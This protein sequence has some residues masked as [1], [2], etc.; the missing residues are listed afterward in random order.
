MSSTLQTTWTGLE[1]ALRAFLE[2]HDAIPRDC[3][4][5]LSQTM[6]T[7]HHTL[8]DEYKMLCEVRR[9]ANRLWQS[10]TRTESPSDR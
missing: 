4:G 9:D 2:A 8:G 6:R 1:Y 7:Q 10:L 3:N 5:A